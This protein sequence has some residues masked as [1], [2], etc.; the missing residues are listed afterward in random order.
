MTQLAQNHPILA[1][2]IV[3]AATVAIALMA[4]IIRHAIRA[5][6]GPRLGFGIAVVIAI[7]VAVIGGAT[8]FHAVAH[9][10]NSPLIP[11][12]ADGMVIACT[13]L[14]LA[15]MTHGWRIPGARITTYVFII[16]SVLINMASVAGWAAKLGH[17]L[18][19]LAYAVLV[20][21]LAHLLR[22]QMRLAQPPRA[23]LS[24]LT[25]ITSPLI[26]TRVWLHLARTGTNDPIAARAIV[27][28]FIR[29]SSRLSAVCPSHP[30]WLP[31][32]RARAARSAALHAIRDGLL[33]AADVAQLLP[34]DS[35][36][37]A[38]LLALIDRAALGLPTSN[39]H[40]APLAV[41]PAVHHPVQGCTADSVQ[42]SA[43]VNGSGA[44]HRTASGTAAEPALLPPTPAGDDAELVAWLH[45]HAARH[46]HGEPLS[47][48]AVMRLLASGWPK[49]KRIHELAGWNDTTDPDQADQE[50]PTD[51]E[52]RQLQTM[53][54]P[55]HIPTDFQPNQT[56]TDLQASRA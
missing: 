46:N 48:R 54:T 6:V 37:P 30:T 38:E 16:G 32:G 53:P 56:E 3:T 8:S 26:T 27:Q 47:A 34:T 22:L 9:R 10:F 39:P 12:V 14:R 17:A 43:S 7:A 52:L 33:S 28:Q 15:A 49:A 2:V 51:T 36:A 21:M 1:G 50:E 35:I 41:H 11:L 13:A 31:V 19:P 18:A 55:S 25:W 5:G 20:E 23:R 4:L 29:T 42:R 44:V 45:R 40:G 24:T